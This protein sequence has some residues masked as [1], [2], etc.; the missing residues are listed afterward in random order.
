M[1]SEGPSYGAAFERS[2][3]L[4]TLLARAHTPT[5]PDVIRNIVMLRR[6][7]RC[8][9]L[10][11]SESERLLRAMPF[12]AE[13]SVTAYQD[14]TGVRIEVITI[15]EPSLVANIGIKNPFPWVSRVT[16][17]NGNLLGNGV[18]ASAQWRQGGYYRDGYAARYTNYQL[19]S[20][21]YQ[22]DIRAARRE[23]GSDWVSQ[24]S[25]PFL[26][27]LQRVAWRL[28][29]GQ[30]NEYARFLRRDTLNAAI[31]V[32]REYMDAGALTRV[33]P[34]G[35]RGLLGLQ[36][37]VEDVDP[38]QGAVVITPNGILPDSVP[39]LAGRYA[40]WRSVRLNAL[41]GF[42]RVRFVRVTGFDAV[43]GSQDLRTGIQI[44][45]TVGR[46]L[47]TSRGVARAELY[48]GAEV[49]AGTGGSRSFA[50][51]EGQ[52]EVRRRPGVGWEDLLSNGR[53]AWYLKPHPRHLITADLS[54]STVHESR[55]PVQLSLGDRRGGLRGFRDTW[56]AGGARVVGRVE[57]RWRVLGVGGTANGAVAVFSDVGGVRAGDV[58][59]GSTS[60]VKQSVG[61]SL[62]VAIPPRS[63]R[64]WRVDLAFPVRG[65]GGSRFELRMTSD[66]RTQLFW[67]AP[68]DIR[69]ARERVVPQS[70]FR[71]P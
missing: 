54:W 19:W 13:A 40:P 43:S 50:A 71:W 5:A 23:V 55:V 49:Y 6:G 60:G 41:L 20:R 44:S 31:R 17:G 42:R 2:P 10:R 57:E 47:P 24:V 65:G 37:S 70:I 38:G 36:F 59:F 45:S 22:L 21:P 34:P 51:V 32:G 28:S 15:D 56:L 26:T 33:G 25:L 8:T 14:G 39:S 11:R 16:L 46:A 63:Q 66:D 58:P 53:A 27:D 68:N 61:A 18:Y 30:S 52:V 3:A 12:I 69:S 7:D 35:R 9:P 1:R 67:R 48:A 4:G 62:I 29:A 64:M